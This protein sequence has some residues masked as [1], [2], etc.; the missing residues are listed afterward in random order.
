MTARESVVWMPR[1]APL[2]GI[3]YNPD[4]QNDIRV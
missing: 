1:T 3:S 4:N 2:A